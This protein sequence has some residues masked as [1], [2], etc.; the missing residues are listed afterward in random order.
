[1]SQQHRS[2]AP[3]TP[4]GPRPEATGSEEESDKGPD[5]TVTKVVAGAGAAATSAAVGSY[6]G[7]AGTVAGAALGSV[8]LT[9]GSTLYQR[10]LDRTKEVVRTRIRVVGDRGTTAVSRT[11]APRDLRDSEVTIPMPRVSP[12][13]PETVLLAPPAPERP[14]RRRLAVLAGVTVL[15]FALGLLVVTGV[16]WAKGSPLSGGEAGT[17]VG[18]VLDPGPAP[19]ADVPADDGAPEPTEEPADEGEPTSTPEPTPSETADPEDLLEEPTGPSGEPE[20]TDEPGL[21]DEVAPTSR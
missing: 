14:S 3:I 18:R 8:V 21:L 12:E 7:A 11:V 10:S 1:M 2:A 20:P 6:L 17:S 5:L 16:E 15:A 19:A 4:T 13:E 9:I